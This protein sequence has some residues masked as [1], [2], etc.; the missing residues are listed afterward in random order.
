MS[1]A[2]LDVMYPGTVTNV[3]MQHVQLTNV[4]KFFSMQVFS[5]KAHEYTC[6]IHVFSARRHGY[7]MLCMWCMC[8]CV[9][10]CMHVCMY[11]LYSIYACVCVCVCVLCVV[12]GQMQCNTPLSYEM[13]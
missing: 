12:D 8:V 11:V 13:D 7:C 6:I 5:V 9:Y 2:P 3:G 10:M 1:T 4:M